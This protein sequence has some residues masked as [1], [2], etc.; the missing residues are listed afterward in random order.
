MTQ[1][2]EDSEI[3]P[4]RLHPGQI[5]EVWIADVGGGSAELVC[6]PESWRHPTGLPTAVGFYSTEVA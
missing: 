6:A 4:R 1:Y 3:V 2:P 5:A